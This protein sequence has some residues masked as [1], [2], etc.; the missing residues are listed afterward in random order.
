MKLTLKNELSREIYEFEVE[1]LQIYRYY[2][3]FL[4]EL[5]EGIQ[6]GQ[7]ALALYND[8]DELIYSD[9]AQVGDYTD[10]TPSYSGN[11]NDNRIVYNG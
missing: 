10:T 2:Y 6:D 1:D 3:Q 4:I 5:P 7:Y 9:I 11:N 8:D